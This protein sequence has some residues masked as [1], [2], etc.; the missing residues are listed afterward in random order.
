M[1]PYAG[2]R[3]IRGQVAET[4][5]ARALSLPSSASLT[6]AQQDRVLLLLRGE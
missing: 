1:Q 6:A 4:V 3:A 5:F 2:L